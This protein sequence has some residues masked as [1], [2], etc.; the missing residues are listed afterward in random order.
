MKVAIVF[1]HVGYC[2]GWRPHLATT[3]ESGATYHIAQ[4]LTYLYS[5]CR[6]FTRDVRVFDFNFLTF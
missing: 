1:P 2:T 3:V 5:I 4:A 6:E